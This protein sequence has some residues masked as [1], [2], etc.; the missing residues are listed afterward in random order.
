MALT[1][2]FS[3]R[4]Q[5]IGQRACVWERL[6]GTYRL[7]IEEGVGDRSACVRVG[8]VRRNLQSV[9]GEG[10]RRSVSVRVCLRDGCGGTYR[11]FVEEGAGDRS[12]CM[13]ACGTR[14]HLLAVHRGR[15]G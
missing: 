14:R 3:S 5:V 13:R 7:F 12:A 8:G 9:G 10:S 11:L 2:C 1:R 6:G 15:S 4:E